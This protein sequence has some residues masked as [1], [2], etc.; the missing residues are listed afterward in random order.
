MNKNELRNTILSQ[1]QL[2]CIGKNRMQ[3]EPV[4]GQMQTRQL[5]QAIDDLS[6]RG[7]GTLVL[8]PGVYRTGALHLKNGVEL[9]LASEDTLVQFVPDDPAE[10]YPLVFSHWEASPCYNF[11]ALLYACDAQDI[12]V[13]GKGVLDGGADA[14]H[15]WNWHHQV[16]TSWSENKLDLQLADRRTLRSMNLGGVPVDRRIFGEGHYLRPNFF[17]P[18]RCQRVLLQGVTLR[19]SPMWQLNPVLCS[20]V[21]VDGVTLS[22]HGA[23]NDGCDP[24]SCNGVWIK[25]CRF[26]TG[27]DCISLKSGRDRDGRE[28]NVPC[29]NILIENNDFADG[30][31]GVALG[32]EMSGGIYNVLASGN[33]FASPNLTYALRLKT[34]ARRGGAVERVMLCDS[35]MDHVHGAAV[36]GTMLYE[37]GRNGDSLPVFRDITMENITA[38]GGDYGVFLEA[39]PEVPITGLVM[40]NITIDGVRQCL[41]SMNWKDAVVENVTINGK[42]FPRPGYVRIL[43]VP[44]IGGTVT[45][46]AESCG[47]QEPLTF[48]WEASEDNKNWTRCGGGE[49]IA[50]PDGAAYLRV[51]AAN[52]AGDRESSRSYRV[53]P[54]PAQGAAP[55]LYCRGMLLSL[56]HI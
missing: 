56:I 25:N 50:V 20:S 17:Q 23:N 27:D 3:V 7:G 35:V 37:D 22:S 6:W 33:R 52:P 29:R 36:H 1:I 51:S 15:W 41:R 10:N 42:R 40:R 28:A 34:N 18:I 48:C 12:A 46:S 19:N 32:S 43:G 53:L 11:S 21:V 44:Y 45:A 8:Q 47:A 13:T 14:D 31:G 5:Q 39:F 4:S 2:P 24:E 54:A 30:H 38:H 26:D 55:R 49:T 16:E 9:H